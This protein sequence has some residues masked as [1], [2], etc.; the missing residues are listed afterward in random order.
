MLQR[1]LEPTTGAPLPDAVRTMLKIRPEH[2]GFVMF[3]TDE[4][5]PIIRSDSRDEAADL[6]TELVILESREQLRCSP[7]STD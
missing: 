3:D 5:E 2:A 4:Q 1:P 7:N 6:V